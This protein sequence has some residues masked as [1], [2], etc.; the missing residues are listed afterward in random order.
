MHGPTSRDSRLMALIAAYTLCCASASCDLMDSIERGVGNAAA[1]AIEQSQGLWVARGT[2]ALLEAITN[3]FFPVRSR[4]F[5]YRLCVL[6]CYQ[7]NAI[8]LPGGHIYLLK[9]F[10]AHAHSVDELAGVIAH[11]MGHLEDRD[12]QRI[13]ARQLLWSGIAGLLRRRGHSS[14][15]DTALMVGLLSSLRHSRRQEAQADAEGVRLSFLAGYHP[16]G[17]LAFL[18]S[19]RGERSSWFQRLFLTHPEPERR[20][21][22]T[23]ER[24]AQW[25]RDQPLAAMRLA[26]T[27]ESRGRPALAC[28]VARQCRDL[29]AHRWWAEREASRLEQAVGRLSGVSMPGPKRRLPPRELVA[30]LQAIESDR[31]INEAMEIA[32]AVDPEPGDLRYA[33]A[34]GYTVWTLMRLRSVTDAGH[35]AAY[36]LSFVD[37]SPAE[38]TSN[39]REAGKRLE[40]ARQAGWTLAAVLAELLASGPGEPLGRLNSA[41]LS[42]MLAQVSWAEHTVGQASDSVEHLLAIST[43]RLAE[44]HLRALT[45]MCKTSPQATELLKFFVLAAMEKDKPDSPKTPIDLL[46]HW[47][48]DLHMTPP[49]AHNDSGAEDVYILST[50]AFRQVS[51]ELSLVLQVLESNSDNAL[52][53][54][55]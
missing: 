49:S 25:I 5:P 26:L 42:R 3:D 8:A 38:L 7:I 47:S 34:L 37:T 51:E 46:T 9:G 31:R 39:L 21:E 54:H 55:I 35:E 23:E 43:V 33:S 41:Q 11:E 16:E 36:R 28:L 48:A 19:L 45:T 50:L 30:V 15:A 6:D 10:L 52:R 20:R 17:L 12:F 22:A 18:S 1:R 44:E 24:I 4:H 2:S 29:P 32:Q 53:S 13:V 27:L 14:A 40:R